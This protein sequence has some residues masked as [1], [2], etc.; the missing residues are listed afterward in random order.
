MET[1]TKTY[2][3]YGYNIVRKNHYVNAHQHYEYIVNVTGEDKTFPS[4]AM[5]KKYISDVL[6]G[7]Q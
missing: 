3:H 7:R 6:Y 4:L 5:A 2:I 1:E